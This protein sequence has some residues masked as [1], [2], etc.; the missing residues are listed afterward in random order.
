MHDMLIWSH[1]LADSNRGH[2]CGGWV[3]V[4]DLPRVMGAHLPFL[5]A[6]LCQILR[7]RCTVFAQHVI[8]AK[9]KV[10]VVLVDVRSGFDEYEDISKC[11]GF[12]EIAFEGLVGLSGKHNAGLGLSKG[13]R[14]L[15]G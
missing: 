3:Q 15:L 5:D 11:H 8:L 12:S 6:C 10:V 9:I 13:D 7:V 2:T 4:V 1:D 14:G